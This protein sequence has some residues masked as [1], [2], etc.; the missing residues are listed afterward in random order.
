MSARA[1]GVLPEDAVAAATADALKLGEDAYTAAYEEYSV[2][3]WS[4]APLWSDPSGDASGESHE[5]GD[6]AKPIPA[7]ATLSG[8]NT[9]VSDYFDTANLRGVRLFRAS[10]GALIIP[11]VDY[12]E[13]RNGF[14]RMHVPLITNSAEA[15]STE[16]DT[17]YHMRRGEVWFVD[18][19][20]VHSGGVIGPSSRLH[21]VLDFSYDTP[22]EET[23][24]GVV[25]EAGAPMLID[26]P[27]LPADLV[28]TYLA[29][30]PFLDAA[31]WRDLVHIL[32][33]VHLRYDVPTGDVYDWLEVMAHA[34]SGPDREILIRDAERMK[35]YFISDGPGSTMTYDALWSDTLQ[36]SSS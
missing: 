15:R 28:P 20:R 21:L 13:H 26:R 27:P 33:R 17:C 31:G 19:N 11:H 25:P 30:A 16:E 12:L 14:T 35:R 9:L 29:L 23:L 8:I 1:V 34:N 7:V 2:G 24:A 5:H 3:S 18:G 32:A 6:P 4:L 36:K 22:P 10:H